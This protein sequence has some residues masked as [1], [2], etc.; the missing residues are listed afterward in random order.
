MLNAGSSTP[1]RA[2][3]L[4][5][6]LLA[7]LPTLAGA[8]LDVA[9]E[10]GPDPAQPGESLRVAITVTNKGGT[11]SGNVT[12]ELP[13]PPNLASLD[14]QLISDGGDCP[15]FSCEANETVVWNLGSLDPGT[16]ITVDLPPRVLSG[17]GA[18]PNGT[19]ITFAAEAFDSGVSAALAQ[20]AVTVEAERIFDLVIDEDR[21]P[22]PAGAT[23]TYEI[24][25]GNR[26][27]ETTTNTVLRFPLPPST[28]LVSASGNGVLIG[29]VVRWNVG[30]LV[31]HEGGRETVRVA[32]GAGLAEG[33]IRKPANASITGDGDFLTHQSRATTAF[34]AENGIRL[35]LNVAASPDPPVPGE[36]LRVAIMVTN[37]T[38][39]FATNVILRLR[40]PNHLASLD[41]SLVSDGGECASF[42]CEFS[43]TATW[44]L[45]TLPPG[46]GVMVTLPPLI[47]SPAGGTLV[48]FPVSAEAD[49]QSRISARQTLLVETERIFDLA[50]E[51]ERSPTS[52][53]DELTYTVVYGNR[54]DETTTGTL[55]RVPL[56]AGVGLVSASDGGTL[57][58]GG[59]SW[60]LG[61]LVGHQGGER[62]ITVR[63]A[64]G[65]AE[66]RQLVIDPATIAGQGTFLAHES[67]TRSVGRIENDTRLD[68]AIAVDRDPLVPGE[69]HGIRAVVTN[70]SG[71]DFADN[72]VLRLRFPT[73]F[74]SLD[75]SLIIGGDCPSF[76]CEAREFVTFAIGTLPPGGG[77][78]VELPPGVLSGLPGGAVISVPI[79][80][81]ATDRSRT[82]ATHPVLVRASRLFDLAVDANVDPVPVQGAVIYRVSYGNRSNEAAAGTVLRLPFPEGAIFLGASNGGFPSGNVVAWNLDLVAAGETGARRAAFGLP[83][84]TIEGSLLRAFDA[85]IRGNGTVFVHES[86][87]RDARR[88]EDVGLDLTVEASPEPVLPNST[89]DTLLEVV[90]TS[91]NFVFGPSIQM[92]F[93]TAFFSLDE[94]FVSDGGDCPSFGCDGRELVTWNLADLAPG[95]AVD[96]SLPPV[97]R[98]TTP[99]GSLIRFWAHAFSGVFG[100]SVFT[101]SI[102]VGDDFD[103]AGPIDPIIFADG[104]ESGN[105]SA[106]SQTVP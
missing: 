77:A 6:L 81:D 46:R 102:A 62:K 33:S 17:G 5:V 100:Q 101:R 14:E 50:V 43:E 105:L 82:L 67:R 83:A 48:T 58:G 35:L 37:P 34:R 51:A 73:G 8:A 97:V 56:P 13:Y 3:R 23:L 21:D 1:R 96:V 99:E 16:G 22:I 11:A 66:G 31:G 88:V 95:A 74:A 27:N 39:S 64:D 79:Q 32:V 84:S 90:N 19:V 91:P 49:G 98:N 52:A 104:F 40:Y 89:L 44:T 55:L 57:S 29:G 59:V 92:R 7:A 103:P 4:A 70:R 42:S 45:G 25:Y 53:G 86:R 30:T 60:S 10:A 9:V 26:S 68:V 61:T 94:S 2:H 85:E 24:T 75:E 47:A 12:V 78:V 87:N 72:V 20:H 18:P 63:L 93:P 28:G 69:L 15:S 106:W 41:E 71:I 38:A 36:A 54:S 65:L 76:S 80:A